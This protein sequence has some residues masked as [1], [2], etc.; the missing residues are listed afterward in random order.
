M[1][2][3]TIY[4]CANYYFDYISDGEFQENTR[5]RQTATYK[6]NLL[7]SQGSGGQFVTKTSAKPA[8]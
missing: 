2:S 6:G 8:C 7:L 1:L 4:N 3:I 5:T